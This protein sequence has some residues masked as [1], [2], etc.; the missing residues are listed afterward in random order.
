MIINGETYEY[1]DMTLQRLI[2]KL[3]LNSEAIVAEVNG[4]IIPRINFDSYIVDKEAAVELVAF[5]GGG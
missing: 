5:V 2:N 1:A 4:E 3:A